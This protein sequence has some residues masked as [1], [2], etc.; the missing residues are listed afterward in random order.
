[1]ITG[2]CCGCAKSEASGKLAN[3]ATTTLFGENFGKVAEFFTNIITCQRNVNIVKG[4]FATGG[5][6]GAWSYFSYSNDVP[7]IIYKPFSLSIDN[8]NPSIN[9]FYNVTKI[10]GTS[11]SDLI[12]S[13]PSGSAIFA[14]GGLNYLV[15]GKGPDA[16][17]F[18]LCSTDIIDNKVSVI[19]GFNV[20]EDQVVFFCTKAIIH[21]EDITILHETVNNTDITYV[22]VVGNEKNS[23]IALI[24]NIELNNSDI[25]LNEKW[26]YT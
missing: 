10:K 25:I 2:H 15:A 5:V 11:E 9:K 13:N 26:S 20:L 4:L 16:F 6:L 1:M 14:I 22:H 17:Y 23:S 21:P 18:S 24:G 12:I 7:N 3:V 8:L 19:E